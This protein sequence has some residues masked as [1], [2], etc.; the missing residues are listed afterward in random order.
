[1]KRLINDLIRDEGMRLKPY[2]DTVGKLTIGV[3]RNLDDNGITEQEALQLLMNDIHVSKSELSKLDWFNDLSDRR[4]EA[5]INM[6]FNLGLTRLLTFKNMIAAL[7]RKE[8]GIAADEA[9]NSKWS[10]Q[11]G[12]RSVRIANIIR[13]GV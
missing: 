2:K 12:A 3:G 5:I 9:L 13:Y 6:H 8:F 1:M 10:R 4:Q 7:E 11:V